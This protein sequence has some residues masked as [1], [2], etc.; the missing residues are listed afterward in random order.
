MAIGE[1]NFISW[2]CEVTGDRS[3]EVA[4]RI[5]VSPSLISRYAS[6]ERRPTLAVLKKIRDVYGI[7]L[8]VLQQKIS[9]YQPDVGSGGA[10][11][12]SAGDGSARIL[13]LEERLSRLRNPR[14]A[15]IYCL[16]GRMP[17]A[18]ID[19]LADIVQLELKYHAIQ[20][21]KD[22]EDET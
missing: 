6:G 9:Q 22:G 20:A 13:E 4:G 21:E 3:V 17:Q 16:G 2:L 11:A 8:D 15:L 12:A 5:D 14:S 18:S 10:P 7:H 1:E 19:K